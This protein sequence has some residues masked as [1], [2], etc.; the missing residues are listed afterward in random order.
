MKNSFL[1]LLIFFVLLQTSFAEQLPAYSVSY[2]PARNALQDGRD[3]IALA[4]ATNRRVLIEVGGEWCKWCHVLDRFLNNSA[5]IKR[6][7][8]Q[9]FVLLKVNVSDENSN[10]EFLKAFPRVIG[11]PHIFVTDSNGNILSSNDIGEFYEKGA[12]SVKR[13]KTFFKRWTIEKK[14]TNV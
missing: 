5:D 3:A 10:S 13:F 2:D 14:T 4:K 11:Y 9:T 12:Y 7:L 1:S 8:H 6:Q